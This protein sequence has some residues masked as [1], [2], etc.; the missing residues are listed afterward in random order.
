[1]SAAY[2]AIISTRRASPRRAQRYTATPHSSRELRLAPGCVTYQAQFRVLQE[3]KGSVQTTC[4]RLILL[5]PRRTNLFFLLHRTLISSASTS[6]SIT[7]SLSLSSTTAASCVLPLVTLPYS[8]NNLPVIIPTRTA[9]ITHHV[10]SQA[11][12]ECSRRRWGCQ[13]R[14]R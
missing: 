12:Q 8:R 2:Q 13:H 5:P 11:R 7:T 10:C 4:F 3:C 6:T 14:R 9:R 1:M